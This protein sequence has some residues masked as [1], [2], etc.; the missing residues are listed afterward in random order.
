[1]GNEF[2]N[3]GTHSAEY[4]GDARDFWWN[5]DYLR[6]LL[7]RWRID[8]AR[9]VLDVGCGVGHWGQLLS[10]V[11]PEE[12][13]FTG[14]DRE[15]LWVEKAAERAEAGGL[16]QR[17]RYQVGRAEQLPFEDNSFDLVTCQTVLMHLRDPAVALQEMTRV[18][19]PGGVVLVTE[20]VNLLGA[21]MLDAIVLNE[22]A[23]SMAAL[24]KFQL[25][26]Q[27]GKAHAGE[28]NDWI[29]ESLPAL[30]AAAGLSEIELRLNDRVNP[31]LPPY[32][33]DFAR[34]LVDEAKDL[35]N[36]ERWM[37]DR[38]TTLRYFVAGGG[39]D[40]EFESGW[41]RILAFQ[42]RVVSA[43]SS[44]RHASAGSQSTY[45]IRGRKPSRTA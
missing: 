19:R 44:G 3:L 20:P 42:R 18:T 7:G 39:Q 4:F 17:F 40:G 37:W 5:E 10:R 38:A 11:L 30:F 41:L 43:I 45:I 35:S 24:M 29:G 34:A 25:H 1:M 31:L 21:V 14:V 8:E 15:P 16:A 23:E 26:C 13:S 2:K 32:E 36:R 6:W 27:R 28:G 12:C 33:S 22:P 9:T